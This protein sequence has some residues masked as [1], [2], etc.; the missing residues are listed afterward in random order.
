MTKGKGKL[1]LPKK[2]R[3]CSRRLIERVF[4]KR[5]R[6][7]AV[8]PIRA[9]FHVM[10]RENEDETCVEMLVSVSKR[11][12]KHAIDRNR[13]KRQIREAYRKQ[14]VL[15]VGEFSQSMP[16]KKL[17]IAF[18][19]WDDKIH[20]SAYIEGK[21]DQLLRRVAQALENWGEERRQP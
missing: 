11:N 19:Y 13:V 1:S 17:L 6:S 16:Q 15:L 20:S 4:H 7:L 5:S 2:E 21:M 8:W 9:C 14:K 18:I 3:L 10:E 12:F